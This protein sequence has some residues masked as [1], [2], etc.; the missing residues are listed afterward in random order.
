M[1]NETQDELSHLLEVLK[2][3]DTVLPT[4]AKI[5]AVVASKP[6]ISINHLADE[7]LLP[8]Q[9]VSRQV[10]QLL[11]RYEDAQFSK[12]LLKQEINEND[13]KKRSLILTSAGKSVLNSLLSAIKSI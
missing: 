1:K 6:G 9:T 10:G 2:I 12:P 3:L 5:L 13:P 7:L 8:Q 11:G 4:Y